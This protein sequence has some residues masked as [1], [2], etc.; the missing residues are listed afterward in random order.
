[1]V[2]ICWAGEAQLAA[3]GGGHVQV[4]HLHGG[5][6]LD[7]AARGQSWGERIEAAGEGY[8]EAIGE[9]GDEDVRLD[10]FDVLMED[11]TD[12]EVALDG[13]ERFFDGDE[14]E[15][16]G[17]QIGGIAAQEIASLAAACLA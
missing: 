3:V 11:R 5:E 6:L 7:D 17:P 13:L 9:E 8:I 2:G 16:I 10:A 4:D 14:L 12:G 15:I 1:M